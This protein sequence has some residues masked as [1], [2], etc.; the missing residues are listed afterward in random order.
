MVP[1][2]EALAELKLLTET[3]AKSLDDQFGLWSSPT[4]N[5]VRA[6]VYPA[7][8]RAN[9]AVVALERPPATPTCGPALSDCAQ[10]LV[11]LGSGPGG[12]SVWRCAKCGSEEWL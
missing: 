9:A 3:L 11:G 4:F 6:V 8:A 1:L 7:W 12:L 10:H 2:S 5:A